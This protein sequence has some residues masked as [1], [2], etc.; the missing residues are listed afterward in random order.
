M[1]AKGKAMPKYSQEFFKEIERKIDRVARKSCSECG[2]MDGE[3]PQIVRGK[4]IDIRK[5]TKAIVRLALVDP[6]GPANVSSEL[7]Q[8]FKERN[9]EGIVWHHPDGRMAKIKARDFGI[10]RGRGAEAS[11]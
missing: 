10:K 9:I 6:K 4:R 5:K 1:A 8:F 11:Q 7:G 2:V 3:R